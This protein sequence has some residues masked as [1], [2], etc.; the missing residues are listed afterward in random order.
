MEKDTNVSAEKISVVVPVYM[1]KDFLRE[2]CQRVSAALA[3]FVRDFEIILVNDASPDDC[4][5]DILQICAE[6]SKIKGVNLSRN[7]GQHYAITAGLTFVSG[8]WIVVMDCDLQDVPEEIP[9]LY[10]KAREGFDSVFAQRIDRQDSYIKCLESKVFYKVFGWLSG[11]KLDASIANFG[12]YRRSVIQAILSMGDGTRYLPAMSQFVGFRQTVCPVMHAKRASGKSSY[13]LSR[14]LKLA[15]NNILAFSNKPLRLF[16]WLGFFTS[17]LSFCIFVIFL[18][19]YLM[20]KITVLGWAS[21]ILS[22]WFVGGILIFG[23]GLIGIYLGK[24]FDQTKQRPLFFVAEK[25][26]LDE[27]R[28]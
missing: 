27:K 3:L 8:D 20:N 1:G 22:V 25:I 2:L 28:Q 4:W 17:F 7:F 24:T 14:L 19:L 23:L 12:I 6:D 9:K 15:S 11:T 13:S 10:T 16:T 5:G 18:V 21:L 26:N